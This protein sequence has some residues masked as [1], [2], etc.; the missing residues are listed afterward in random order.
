ML[1]K[2]V[3]LEEPDIAFP[4]TLQMGSLAPSAFGSLLELVEYLRM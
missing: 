2:L 1:A 3:H 4:L